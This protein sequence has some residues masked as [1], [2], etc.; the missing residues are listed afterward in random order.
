MSENYDENFEPNWCVFGQG[1][2]SECLECA[3]QSIEIMYTDE[4]IEDE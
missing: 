1:Y 3:I 2:C 4:L